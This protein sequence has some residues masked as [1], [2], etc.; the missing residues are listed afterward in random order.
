MEITDLDKN[1]LVTFF[2][3]QFFK[4]TKDNKLR[5]SLLFQDVKEDLLIGDS[6]ESLFEVDYFDKLS[7]EWSQN[8]KDNP[9][10]REQLIFSD[11]HFFQV[12]LTSCFKS[13]I[14]VIPTPD[15]ELILDDEKSS[16]EYKFSIYDIV[17]DAPSKCVALVDRILEF[18]PSVDLITL[19]IFLSKHLEFYI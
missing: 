10:T 6:F 1:V 7:D 5:L 4:E 3:N 9:L 2:Q 15:S 18:A 11:I 17:C 13:D 19:L 12:F 14:A 8:Y 16:C